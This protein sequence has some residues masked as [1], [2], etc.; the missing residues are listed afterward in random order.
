MVID[1]ILDRMD[2]CVYDK[3]YLY[4]TAETNGFD[5]ICKA[6]DNKNESELKQALNNYIDENDYSENLH[7]YINENNW[8]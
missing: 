5:D 8:L 4:D 3:E 6:F 7:Q 1:A 2:G